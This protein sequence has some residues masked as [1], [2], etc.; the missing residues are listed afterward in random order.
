M[1][2]QKLISYVTAIAMTLAGTA[3]A[4]PWYAPQGLPLKGVVTDEE[5][6]EIATD[7]L[8]VQ[9]YPDTEDSSLYYIVPVFHAVAGTIAGAPLINYSQ[10]DRLK[11]IRE[12]VP[13]IDKS[14]VEEV[15]KERAEWEPSLK[16]AAA[17]VKAAKTKKPVDQAYVAQLESIVREIE[18]RIKHPIVPYD[19]EG[20]MGALLGMMGVKLPPSALHEQESRN[21]VVAKATSVSGGDLVANISA[22]LVSRER[23]ALVRYLQR[24][25]EAG[26]PP[27]RF[28]TMKTAKTKFIPIKEMS[29]IEGQEQPV[30]MF[31]S[32]DGAGNFQ[33]A[34]LNID[35][36]IDAAE[37]FGKSPP[38]LILPVAISGKRRW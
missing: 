5:G 21:A 12:L 20:E 36:G 4:I 9:F 23:S 7:L 33:G 13:L 31:R 15:A 27:L 34:T 19:G 14:E 18:E 8:N 11:R 38:P 29:K 30:Q 25:A 1:D 17:A 32:V 28:A 16:E 35:L 22:N 6:A 26:L 37:A 10:I 3:N 24:R 2:K